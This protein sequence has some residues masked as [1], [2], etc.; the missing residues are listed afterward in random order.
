MDFGEDF[1]HPNVIVSGATNNLKQFKLTK[2]FRDLETIPTETI[3]NEK[4]SSPPIG[5]YKVN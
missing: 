4:W 3:D 5:M 1:V 2:E